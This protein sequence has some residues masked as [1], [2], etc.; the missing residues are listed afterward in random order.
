MSTLDF[1]QTIAFVNLANTLDYQYAA[2]KSGITVD[3]LVR[4]IKAL[5]EELNIKLIRPE[6]GVVELTEIGAKVLPLITEIAQ[7]HAKLLSVVT[8][9]RKKEAEEAIKVIVVPGF[10]NYQAAP[11]VKKLA[12]Q[13]KMNIVE[14]VDPM[15]QLQQ[16]ESELAFISYAGKLPDDFEVLSVGTDDLVAYI[17]AR[18]P[19]SKQKELTLTDL[20]AE[21]FLTLNHQNPFAVFV[22]Q[23]CAA[24]GFEL[25]SVFEGE[26]G[27][28]LVNMVA[29]G[30]GITLLMEQ[31]ISEN[32]DSKVVKVPIVPKV[33]QNLAFVR[34]KNVEHTAEQEELWQALKESFEK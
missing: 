19:L 20:K 15:A 27:R 25:Y 10:A 4:T 32:L 26:K 21:K 18:N 12:Q 33:T 31:S 34:R 11:V 16:G 30:M 1:K 28:T 3:E 24:A 9:Y 5:E 14:D 7:K 8:D 22:Q 6:G 29:L 23:V 2:K 13:H 17:P